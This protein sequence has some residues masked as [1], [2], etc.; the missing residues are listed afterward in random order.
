[1]DLPVGLEDRLERV[2]TVKRRMDDIKGSAEAIAALGILEGLGYVPLSVED[3]AVRHF[4]SKAS[5]VMTNVPG[6]QELLHMKGRRIQHI[7]PWVPRAGHVGLGVS[8]FS[9]DGTVRLGIACDAGLI[10]DPDTII[11]GFQREFDR[12]ADDLLSDPEDANPVGSTSREERAGEVTGDRQDAQNRVETDAEVGPRNPDRLVEQPRDRPDAI[13]RGFLSG[14]Q[15]GVGYC[16]V[17]K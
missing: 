2:L 14:R 3:Q 1:M 17:H 5:A 4:S 13:Q 10:P 7:M 9:Y 11:D 15:F 12:L 8:I 6:P 16:R